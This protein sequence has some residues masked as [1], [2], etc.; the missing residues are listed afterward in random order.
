MPQPLKVLIAEDNPADA[1]L[2]L[3][4]LRRESFEPEWVRVDNETAYS[5]HL[6]AGFNLVLSDYEMPQFSGLR[7]LELLKQS[8]LDIPFIL[9]SGT[10]GEDIAVMA[11]K[12]G[13]S[14]YLLKDRLARLGQAIS[15][16]LEETRLRK[17]RGQVEESLRL[18][19]SLV[20]NSNDSFEVI[21]PKTARFLDVNEKGFASL[22]Y[23][24][25]E[26]LSLRVFDID[27]TIEAAGWP[28]LVA[29]IRAGALSGAGSRRRKDGST[30]PIEFNV[31]SVKLDREYLVATVRDVTE[32]KELEAQFFRAQRLESVGSL[33][34]GIAHDMNNILAPILMSAPLLRL[35]LSA[36]KT[37]QMLSTIETSA[38]RGADL[39]RQL[40]S[41]GRG[42]DGARRAV[43]LAPLI[44]EI[45]KIAQQT[46]PKNISLVEDIREPTWL[47]IGDTTQ[48]HQILLNLAVNARDAMPQGGVLTL[49]VENVEFDPNTAKMTHGASPGPYVCACVTDTG[50][51][52]PPEIIDKIFDPFFTTKAPGKGTGLGLSTVNGIVKS[53]GGFV[54]IFSK[55]GRGSSFQIYLPA[56][57]EEK[58][59]AAEEIAAKAPSGHG[60]LLLIV[61]DE[62]NIRTITRDLLVKYG[63]QVI[64]ANDGTDATAQYALHQKDIC[65]VI[66]DLE[67]PLMNGV[68]LIQVLKKM[69]PD[70]AVL[71]STG[72][73][74]KEGMESRVADLER[75]GIRTILKKPYT[76]EK[77][78]HA[79]HELLEDK[80]MKL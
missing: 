53:H 57:P 69:N 77:I 50:T 20:E 75:L 61:D 52:M 24:R 72:F 65:A 17:E 38:Q 21:D 26:F 58:K 34:S 67:M 27:P 36:E 44:R 55:V 54:K 14:D 51:G 60:E 28:Q 8:G 9:I 79:I 33:A 39:V 12:A 71:V 6:R 7:A 18:F 13:A 63:Y 64:T 49:A 32:R 78:L 10:I 11:M 48:L 4:Q 35:G 66:T 42:V 16:G 70:V 15:H 25:A 68:T 45:S 30:F 73:M 19:R 43:Q 1:E 46:F 5:D 62:E 3:R 80:R 74:S 2:V 59:D 56:T 76:T 41:F 40:L 31:K 37:E 23:S 22:G 47:V 29:K